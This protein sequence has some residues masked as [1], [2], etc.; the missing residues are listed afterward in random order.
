L[1]VENAFDILDRVT[2]T[3]YRNGAGTAVRSFAY[4]YDP[5]GLLTQKVTVADGAAVTNAYAYDGLGRLVAESRIQ[6]SE[7]GSERYSYDLAGN[8]LA[9]Q[10][11]NSRTNELTN[12]TC[13]YTHNRLDGD[14]YDAAGCVT[15]MT[16]NGVTLALAWN[17]LGQLVS[18]ATNDTFAESY[19]YDP[20]GRRMSTTSLST[21]NH[22]PS[23]IH[24]WYDGAQ[25][26]ADTDASGNL[27]RSYAWGPGIDNLLAVTVYTYPSNSLQP[28][29]SSYY[30]VK[31][32]L[33]SV[34]ALVDASGSVVESYSYNAWGN[35]LSH[36][37]TNER[38]NFSLRFLFQGREFS[39]ATGLYNFRARWYDPASGRWLSKDPIG[40][41]G[42]PNLYAFC[43]N[44]PVNFRD[45]WGLRLSAKEIANI[46]FNELRS[47]SGKGIDQAYIN[48]I[49]AI[50]N[51]DEREA[52]TGR[53]RPRSASTEACVPPVEQKVWDEI[54]LLVLQALSNYYEEG[55]DP[56]GGAL[57][58][59]NRKD[60]G[61]GPFQGH[62]IET[63][64]GPFHNSCPTKEL[65]AEGIYS[66]TYE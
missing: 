46:V 40:I 32:R 21:I 23:T 22:E 10:R 59:N 1:T 56:T 2:N 19:A 17:T 55:I 27:L 64:S 26:V 41:E 14:L 66:N 36:S 51:G 33:G 3:V 4:A 60:S 16:R 28:S 30:A 44:D 24:H 8:R 45:P 54:F 49:Y 29:A 57:H 48:M 9:V 5:D 35:L 58:F 47:L 39:S 7:S 53:K 43:G 18:V 25:C 15:N 34:C 61:T 31:D 11:T 52:T 65:P 50:I 63:Q 20:L 13:T 6:N 12:S 62:E 37:R 42:G 38:T